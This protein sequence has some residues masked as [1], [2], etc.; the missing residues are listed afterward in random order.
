MR[1]FDKIV[2]C[3]LTLLRPRHWLH[4]FVYTYHYI[5]CIYCNC[6]I[7][8][9]VRRTLNK[10]KF[11]SEYWAIH[12]FSLVC[13]QVWC[14]PLYLILTSIQLCVHLFNLMFNIF[15]SYLRIDKLM[16]AIDDGNSWFQFKLCVY[17]PMID[18]QF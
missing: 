2:Y 11:W 12:L 10:R 6:N 4:R 18:F 9:N 8:F 5:L 1:W 7:Y 3:L 16:N 17:I 13:R 14:M 15:L